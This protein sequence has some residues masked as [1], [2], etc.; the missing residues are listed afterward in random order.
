MNHCK[1]SQVKLIRKAAVAVRAADTRCV[2]D[3]SV[4][5][6][7]YQLITLSARHHVR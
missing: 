3:T 4:Y 6:N 5:A 2:C 1:A 7:S